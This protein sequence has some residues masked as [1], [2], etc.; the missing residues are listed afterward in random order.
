MT[1]GCPRCGA[2]VRQGARYCTKCGLDLGLRPGPSQPAPDV[3]TSA[4]VNIRRP[5]S[6][7]LHEAGGA[8]YPYSR[9]AGQSVVKALA[10]AAPAKGPFWVG[11]ALFLGG[12]GLS[13]CQILLGLALDVSADGAQSPLGIGGAL[14][15]SGCLMFFVS[16]VGATLI[17]AGRPRAGR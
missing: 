17:A 2:E 16:L 4:P 1:V 11:L 12:F 3:V 9:L 15:V 14:A 5:E 8:P 13:A 7:S 6:A 10:P